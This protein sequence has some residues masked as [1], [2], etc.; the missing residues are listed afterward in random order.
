LREGHIFKVHMFKF[1]SLTLVL[2]LFPYKSLALS[3]EVQDPCTGHSM[4]LEKVEADYSDVGSL[5]TTML[6]KLGVEYIGSDLGIN[7]MLGTPVGEEAIEIINRLEMR[8]YG[9]CYE[10]D[11]TT[12]EVL[13][14]YFSLEKSMKKVTW[15]FGFAYYKAGEWLSQCERVSKLKPGFICLR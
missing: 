1:L 9:W 14:P 5:T 6:D 8:S 11:G 15:F 2:A 3:F 10:V 13:P 7:T 4:Y 12:P